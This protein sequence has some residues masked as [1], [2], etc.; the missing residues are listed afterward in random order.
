MELTW[1]SPPPLSNDSTPEST[2]SYTEPQSSS[3][4]SST[5][6]R[7]TPT[8]RA[9]SSSTLTVWLSLQRPQTPLAG[10]EEASSP[11]SRNPPPLGLSSLSLT[12][13]GWTN[14]ANVDRCKGKGSRF[15]Y[16]LHTKRLSKA[17]GYTH[18]ET[19]SPT[20]NNSVA[21]RSTM[22]IDDQQAPRAEATAAW[23]DK[24]P[25]QPQKSSSQPVSLC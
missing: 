19:V 23:L 13:A 22:G 9:A 17:L 5:T 8:K 3:S 12:E 24:P 18:R 15:V 20:G 4:A 14:S 2:R 11:S 21:Y 10:G 1:S 16:R 6:K 25:V 7:S